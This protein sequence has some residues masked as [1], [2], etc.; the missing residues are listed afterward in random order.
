MKLYWSDFAS[1]M[2]AGI[3]KYYKE[4]ATVKVA[5]KIKNEIFTATNQLKRFY[6]R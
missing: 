1:E 6:L 2:L 5:K 4:N 3:Y